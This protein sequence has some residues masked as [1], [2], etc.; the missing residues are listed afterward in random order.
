MIANKAAGIAPIKISELSLRSIPNRMRSPK[1]PAPIKA[2][3]VAVPIINTIAVRIP[4]MMTG[5]AIGNSTL[6]SLL[7]GF[8]PI[9]LAASTNDGSTSLIPVYVFRNIGNNA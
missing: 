3:N 6:V 1:P 7:N 9:P 4:A 2:A 5:I 8:I